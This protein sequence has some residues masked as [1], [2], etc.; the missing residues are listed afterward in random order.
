MPAVAA[1]LLVLGVHPPAHADPVQT[2]DLLDEHVAVLDSAADIVGSADV[3]GDG[4]DDLVVSGGRKNLQLW[5]VFAPLPEWVDLDHL[6]PDDGYLIYNTDRDNLHY[7]IVGLVGDVNGDGLDDMAV[8][9]YICG[10]KNCHNTTY[11]V[12]GKADGRPVYLDDIGFSPLRAFG[13]RIEGAFLVPAAA[14]DVNGDGYDDIL[15]AGYGDAYVV[16]GKPDYLSVRLKDLA[17]RTDDVAGYWIDLWTLGHDV[18]SVANAGDVNRDGVPDAVFGVVRN[19]NTRGRAYVVL[20][21]WDTSDIDI[22]THHL[23]RYRI[24]GLYSGSFTGWDVDGN[25]DVNGDGFPDQLVT[26]PGVNF[27]VPGDAFV[28]FGKDDVRAVRLRNPRHHALRIPGLRTEEALGIS[29]DLPG[30]VNG[31]G[32]G[33]VAVLALSD[34]RSSD[35]G[36]VHVVYGSRD[37]LVARLDDPSTGFRISAPCDRFEP[38]SI[39][40]LDEVE[41]VADVD[42]DGLRDIAIVARFAVRG[43]YADEGK[44]L[45]V[46]SRAWTD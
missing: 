35:P 39:N 14:G 36:S 44:I 18:T 12:F 22:E 11:V 43:R 4:L 17:R 7:P 19:N 40:F 29:A 31:D 13:Y 24:R 30:D 32:L 6:L 20:G 26:A 33:D 28:V 15:L 41:G 5:V 8:G 34:Y 3:N 10:E 9:E 38:C 21:K 23:A 2:V 27:S 25:S 46:G 1:A 42:G 16:F 37:R 45:V